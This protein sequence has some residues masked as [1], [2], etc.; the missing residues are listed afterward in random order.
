MA[1]PEGN[2]TAAQQPSTDEKTPIRSQKRT[3]MR[4]VTTDLDR[5]RANQV[6][7]DMQAARRLHLELNTSTRG[8]SSKAAVTK[9]R[10]P[11]EQD[12]DMSE[13][14]TEESED[15]RSS[16][17]SG[18]ADSSNDSYGDS[19]QATAMQGDGYDDNEGD[20]QTITERGSNATDDNT[21]QS[22]DDAH[23]T[24][25]N[26]RSTSS[27]EVAIEAAASA[28]QTKE[29]DVIECKCGNQND[30]GKTMICCDHCNKWQHT[31][32]VGLP[33]G[34]AT[35]EV[36]LCPVCDFKVVSLIQLQDN[37]P[38]AYAKT[39]NPL[40]QYVPKWRAR[41]RTDIREDDLLQM[42]RRK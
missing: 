22:G 23:S 16:E 34:D 25:S 15:I 36:Y 14:S 17:H 1:T 20:D 2:D 19:S 3:T 30:N 21:T 11:S 37:V 40:K 5:D 12:T 28:G 29:E 27:I 6:D 39:N 4:N 24:V 35:N 26:I 38:K 42:L 13:T 10:D 18:Y 41:N 31:K 32:C 8:R 7:Q 9:T 33:E